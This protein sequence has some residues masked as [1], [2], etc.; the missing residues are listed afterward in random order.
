[1]NGPA[2]ARR[3]LPGAVL[4]VAGAAAGTLLATGAAWLGLELPGGLP[5]GHLL[6]ARGWC[7]LAGAAF[8]FSPRGTARRAAAGAALAC[9]ASWLPLSVALAGTQALDFPDGRGAAWLGFTQAVVALVLGAL[10]WTLAAA[11][12]R[13][14]AASR[15][16]APRKSRRG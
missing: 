1:M 14:L 8:A 12:R 15:L 4:L 3:R 7:F 9:A 5:V 10:A 6:A 16:S 13:R 11:L 2:A